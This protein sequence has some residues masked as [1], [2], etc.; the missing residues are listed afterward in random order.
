[1]VDLIKKL[2][3]EASLMIGDGKKPNYYFV[4]VSNDYNLVDKEGE[5]NPISCNKK[6][7]KML[8]FESKYK[9]LGKFVSYDNARQSI[10][11]ITLGDESGQGF[12][13][14]TIW[15]ED[16]LS[17]ELYNR[18]NCFDPAEGLMVTDE[19]EDTSAIEHSKLREKEC[20]TEDFIRNIEDQGE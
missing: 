13:I 2:E 9:C 4:F 7:M 11:Y 12:H 15:I 16:R 19:H 20:N 8:G 17:G 6:L 14:N 3:E 5:V 1:M 10:D 18:T